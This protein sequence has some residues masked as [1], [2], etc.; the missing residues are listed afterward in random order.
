[1]SENLKIV[2]AHCHFWDPTR[3]PYPWLRD[4]PMVPFRYGDYGPIRRPY[5]P[6]DY[7]GDCANQ[8]VAACVHVE[9][10]WDPADPLAETRWLDALAEDTGWPH[11]IVGQA[12]FGRHDIEA[13]LAGHAAFPLVRGIREKPRAAEAP[14]RVIPGAPGSMG[15]AAWR[16][17][18]ALMAKFGL[19]F[20]L[21]TPYWHLAEAAQ[22]ARDFPDTLIILNHSGLPADRSEAGLSAWGEALET[23][24]GQAN[25]AIKISGLGLP[26]KPWTVADNR[27]VV[28]RVLD[29]F[30]PD[31]CMFASNFPVDSLVADYDT[32]FDGFQEI[33]AERP[34]AERGALFHGNAVRYYRMEL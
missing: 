14:H 12:W 5:M 17:G 31:R 34:R 23:F 16:Q 15:D 26:G 20:D 21:Q 18:Y 4:E 28:R 6:Q 11:A 7:L 32:I 25:T 2:D 27:P 24:A 1:M 13:V 29:V 10:Q 33:T 8:N 9:A 30:G 3:N 19:S 22:L